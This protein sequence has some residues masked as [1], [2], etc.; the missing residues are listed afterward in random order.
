MEWS[1]KMEYFYIGLHQPSDAKH[2]SRA[3][4]SINRL[5]TRYKP[6]PS[7]KILL[8]SGAFTELSNYGNYRTP[9]ADYADAVLRLIDNDV[10]DLD[11]IVS[12]DYMCEPMILEKTG[13]TIIDHQK[14]TIERYD[15]LKSKNLPVA[16]LPVLQG[17]APEDYVRHVAMYGNRITAD[18]RIGI[19]S[20]CKRNG[21]PAEILAVLD[22]IAGVAPNIR[23]HGFGIKKTSLKYSAIRR[24]LWSAD[25][26]A[27]SYRGRRH[28]GRSSNDWR[29]AKQFE[30]D[31]SA[32]LDLP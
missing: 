25:S 10:V 31:I 11:M 29:F 28:D 7:C 13:K 12:Q 6:I 27:W 21:R 14:L 19:G 32:L 8:D 5:C 4:I 9:P 26:M 1:G 15:A 16:I 17:Y 20:V 23:M 30:R 18:M 3:C 22:A 24:L 2:F